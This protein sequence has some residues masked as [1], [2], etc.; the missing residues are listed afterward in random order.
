[1]A[2]SKLTIKALTE[3]V[4]GGVTPRMVRHYHQLGLLPQPSRSDGNYRLYSD[5]DV[6]R[7]QRIVALKQQGF[8]IS[9]IQ[10]LLNIRPSSRKSRTFARRQRHWKGY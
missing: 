5:C 7:L 1:M 9:H 8:Q 2:I 6:Q 3:S 4:G 10:K